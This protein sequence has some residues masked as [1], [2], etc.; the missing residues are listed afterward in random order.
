VS[1]GQY[2][3]GSEEPAGQAAAEFRDMGADRDGVGL[4]IPDE[5][6]NEGDKTGEGV[7]GCGGAGPSPR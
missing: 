1:A 5:S 3:G 4:A 7:K 2:R 6:E